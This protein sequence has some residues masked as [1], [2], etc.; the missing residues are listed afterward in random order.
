VIIVLVNALVTC[1]RAL[2]S[3]GPVP[4]TEVLHHESELVG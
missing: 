1:V 2:R 4:T 3:P